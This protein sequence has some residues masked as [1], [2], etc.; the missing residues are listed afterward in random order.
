M[1]SPLYST[2]KWYARAFHEAGL[3]HYVEE[4]KYHDPTV[5]K[6]HKLEASPV[7]VHDLSLVWVLY[8]MGLTM[9]MICISCEWAIHLGGKCLIFN[10]F[11]RQTF[12]ILNLS[13]FIS[14]NSPTLPPLSKVAQKPR[15]QSI[16]Q[17]IATG[18][19]SFQHLQQL[20]GRVE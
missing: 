11:K 7:R 19:E 3:Y 16:S 12:P 6:R 5:A 20:R 15:K 10:F 2:V 1:Y 4:F 8:C 9:C 14:V 17:P 18:S 13:L